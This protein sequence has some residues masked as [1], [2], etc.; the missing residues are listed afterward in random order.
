MSRFD[1]EPDDDVAEEPL[2]DLLADLQ[3]ES[4]RDDLPTNL[5]RLV[6]Y[7]VEHVS[8]LLEAV[9]AGNALAIDELQLGTYRE[10]GKRRPDGSRQVLP[11]WARGTTTLENLRGLVVVDETQ[12]PVTV[13]VHWE[14]VPRRLRLAAASLASEL[15]DIYQP[16][17]TGGR[18]RKN[19]RENH[20]KLGNPIT[21]TPRA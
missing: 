12:D 3:R 1:V 8:A 18:P 14:K 7:G 21:D 10:N 16:R 13:T 15:V 20:R 19:S 4:A 17:P 5:K 6:D 2:V 9:R 11:Y